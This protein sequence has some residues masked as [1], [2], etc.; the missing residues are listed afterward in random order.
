MH[1]SFYL[2]FIEKPIKCASEDIPLQKMSIVCSHLIGG[3][4]QHWKCVR[5]KGEGLF[6]RVQVRAGGRGGVEIQGFYCVSTLW[7][8]PKGTYMTNQLY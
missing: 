2:Y 5:T 3:N 7:M 4:I 8:A 6:E 1:C